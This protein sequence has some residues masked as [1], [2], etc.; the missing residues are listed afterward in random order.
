[1][2]QWRSEQCLYC[3]LWRRAFS[4]AWTLD[5]SGSTIAADVSQTLAVD[6]AVTTQKVQAPELLPVCLA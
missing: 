6:G 4:L 2:F 5:V 1:L 3:S